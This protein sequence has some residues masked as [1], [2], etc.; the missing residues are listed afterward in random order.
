MSVANDI[1]IDLQDGFDR[2]E[3]RI[4]CDE[5]EIY[6]ENDVTTQKLTGMADSITAPMPQ[7]IFALEVSVPSRRVSAKREIEP[8]A[9]THVGISLRRGTIVFTLSDSPFGY[10]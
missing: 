4:A 9:T 5:Q 1:Q 6:H 3:V 7:E 10:A 8:S 2:D